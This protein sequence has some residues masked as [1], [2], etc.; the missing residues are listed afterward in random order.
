MTR[1]L[2]PR[3]R[4]NGLLVS[5]HLPLVALVAIQVSPLREGMGWIAAPTLLLATVLHVPFFIRLLHAERQSA[6][7]EEV[8]P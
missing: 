2:N 4:I 8:T 3:R 7:R 1:Q 5:A 6:T